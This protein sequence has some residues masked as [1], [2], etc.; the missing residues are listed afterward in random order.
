MVVYQECERM[1]HPLAVFLLEIC[2]SGRSSLELSP[3]LHSQSSHNNVPPNKQYRSSWTIVE[4]TIK[5]PW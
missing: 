4:S 2:V 1:E 3:D 5:L